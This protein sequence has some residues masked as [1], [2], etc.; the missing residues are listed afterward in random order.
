MTVNEWNV[1]VLSSDLDATDQV[2]GENMFNSEPATGGKYALV[3]IEVTYRG[4]G[5]SESWGEIDF[6][7]YYNGSV[8]EDVQCGLMMTLPNEYSAS[9][10]Q[11]SGSTVSGNICFEVP[12][13]VD[14][15]LLVVED[16]GWF[17]GDSQR[18]FSLS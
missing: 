11:F 10:E 3:E 15:A 13:S 1:K 16:S 18:F 8:Q 4:E 5:K 2:V 9:Q 7:M 14:D 17:S 6:H 12:S